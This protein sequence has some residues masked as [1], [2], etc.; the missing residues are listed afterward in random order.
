[1]EDNFF[2]Q[3]KILFLMK[4]NSGFSLDLFSVN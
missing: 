4:E 1:L 3:V 2:Y